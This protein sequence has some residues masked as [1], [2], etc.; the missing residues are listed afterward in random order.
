MGRIRYDFKG[1]T[2]AITGASGGIGR[3]IALGFGRAGANVVIGDV[4]EEEGRAVAAEVEALGGR[5]LFVRCDVTDQASAE[6]LVR[7]ALDGFGGLDVLVNSAG[8]ANRKFGDPFTDLPDEDFDLTYSVN[9][10]GMVHTCRAV[11]D[12]FRNRRA[13]RIVN[14]CS[15]VGH[16][17]NLFNVPYAVSKAAS[18]NLTV[19][20]A[21]ELGPYLVTVNALCPGY[22]LTPM[23]EKAAP[24]LIE[25]IP[26]LQGKS[27]AELVEYFAKSNCALGR[28]QTEEDLANGALFLASEG[29]K[30]ITGVVL[31]VAGGYKL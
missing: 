29:A 6:G 23:Y 3:G 19:H 1:E 18:L 21:K 11:Y 13:G 25:K 10:K 4:K 30:N 24:A 17:T 16:S 15:V 9:V 2:V 5:A 7:A 31:D 14:V 28:V 27:A 22:V 20:L 8:M 26:S 12:L